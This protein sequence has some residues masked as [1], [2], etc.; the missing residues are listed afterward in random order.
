[1]TTQV[2]LLNYDYQPISLV[3]LK[4]AI[5][6]IVKQR[7]EVVKSTDIKIHESLFIPKVIRLLK[8]IAFYFKRHLPFSKHNVFM[9]DDFHCVYCGTKLRDKDATVDHILPSSRGGKN[10]FMNTVCSC[11]ECNNK[12]GDR[13]PEEVGYTLRKHPRIP[14]LMDLIQ[15]KFKGHDF[16]DIWEV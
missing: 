11:Y 6:L 13:T 8:S 10:D 15:V 5:K 3:S 12:K 2:V 1:M 4:K 16:S 9:R 14:T 7:V